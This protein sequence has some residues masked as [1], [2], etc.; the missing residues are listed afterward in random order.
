MHSLVPFLIA[1]GRSKALVGS[2]EFSL[3]CVC[4]GG[5]NFTMISFPESD[6]ILE[7]MSVLK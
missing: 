4:K 1:M 5:S 7:L 3:D 6:W 2:V